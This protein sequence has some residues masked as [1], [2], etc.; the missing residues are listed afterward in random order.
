MVTICWSETVQLFEDILATFSESEKAHIVDNDTMA[1]AATSFDNGTDISLVDGDTAVDSLSDGEAGMQTDWVFGKVT[2]EDTVKWRE[3][4]SLL[5][6]SAGDAESHEAAAVNF[7][8][9]F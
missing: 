2:W 9:K 5:C 4:K 6:K 3:F 1:A 8:I 7:D